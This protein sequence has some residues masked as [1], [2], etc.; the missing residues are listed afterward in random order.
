M[1][2]NLRRAIVPVVVAGAA[3]AATAVPAEA[4]FVAPFTAKCS[5]TSIAGI[6]ASFQN[7]LQ[8]N[9]ASQFIASCATTTNLRTSGGTISYNPAGSG[10]GRQAFGSAA[11]VRNAAID[12]IGTDDA[13]TVAEQANMNSGTGGAAPNA[14]G[15]LHVI[16]LVAG[17]VTVSVHYPDN[18]GIPAAVAFKKDAA[19]FTTR[20]HVTNAKIEQVFE[21]AA[22]MDT[23][24]ELLPGI[25]PAPGA[26]VGTV[27]A[28]L[29]IT[30]VARLDSSGTTFAFKQFLKTTNPAFAW[31]EDAP[32]NLA[33]TAWPNDTGTHLVV[34]GAANGAG[35]LEDKV[36]ANNGAIGYADLAT[37]RSKHFDMSDATSLLNS[38]KTFWIPVTNHAGQLKDPTTSAKGYLTPGIHGTLCTTA[39]A[40]GAHGAGC[41]GVQYA[42]VPTTPADI[43]LSN[44]WHAVNPT[45]SSIGY[46]ICPLTYAGVYDDSADPFGL[47]T[48]GE[49]G[50]AR[51]VKDY[52]NYIVTTGQN[53]A[54]S[55]DYSKLPNTTA[56]PLATAAKNAMLAVNW[57][58]P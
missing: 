50:R 22:T 58:K 38:D 45:A 3:F 48:P 23:W 54:A 4:A 2:L 27:C 8:I 47:T 33:N 51:T 37:A 55:F 12:F 15:L 46:A 26:P 53:K 25:L 28:A 36:V 42:N 52:I 30:R 7:L 20:F 34:R 18:C 1:P 21:G 40:C 35:A 24:G 31:S 57:N 14:A 11:G 6:G 39:T 32:D 43:T 13:P 41:S 56:L 5:G 17:A 19:Q 44:A 10:A 16:P 9:M 29:P 49:Q